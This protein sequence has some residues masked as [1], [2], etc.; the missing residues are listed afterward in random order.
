[1]GVEDL[2]DAQAHLLAND[3]AGPVDGDEGEAECGADGDAEE[4]FAADADGEFPGGFGEVE[5]FER[6][7]DGG[8]D[9]EGEEDFE[10]AR[11][12]G[13]A[14]EGRADHDA[15]DSEECQDEGG[16]E[17]EGVFERHNDTLFMAMHLRRTWRPQRS[18]SDSRARV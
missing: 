13:A 4:E 16:D 14:E 12:A 18:S 2:A 7:G 9:D 11:D 10:S 6:G 5:R 17:L 3:F 15:G 1:M 8:G